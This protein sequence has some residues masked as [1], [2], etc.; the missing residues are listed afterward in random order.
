MYERNNKNLHFAKI[1]SDVNNGL[2]LVCFSN[3]KISL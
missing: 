3:F 1:G 2:M